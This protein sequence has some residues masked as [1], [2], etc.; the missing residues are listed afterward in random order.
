[1]NNTT[2]AKY[3]MAEKM[4]R[5]HIDIEEVVLMSGLTKEEVQ[6]IY[7][8]I[9]NENPEAKYLKGL[10]FQDFELGP[11]LFDNYNDTD[12]DTLPDAE[13]VPE[14]AAK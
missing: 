4:L 1:M 5:G 9:E 2:K 14:D 13:A 8:K 6:N 3:N 11:V 7:D 12:N 10:D